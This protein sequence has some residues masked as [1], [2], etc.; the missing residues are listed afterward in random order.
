M[1]WLV[2]KKLLIYYTLFHILGFYLL[3]YLDN[4]SITISGN[5]LLILAP[6][7]SSIILFY[8]YHNL[9]TSDKYIW[10]FLSIGSFCYFIAV[11]ARYYNRLSGLPDLFTM[12]QIIC[13]LIAFIYKIRC[14]GK[15]LNLIKFIFDTCIIMTVA[16]TFSW[17]FIIREILIQ[18]TNHSLLFQLV[19][20]G[21]PLG[22]LILFF[23][24]IV[25]CLGSANFFPSRVLS[26]ILVS[27]ALQVGADSAY[28]YLSLTNIPFSEVLFQPLGSLALLLM[29]I[30]GTFAL[31]TVLNE[32][33]AIPKK[34]KKD[35]LKDSISLR[36]L[37]PYISVI[38]LFMMMIFQNKEVKSLVIGSAISILLVILRHVFTSLE[39]QTLL[40]KYHDLTEKLEQKI[41][42]RTEELS[43]KNQQLLAAVRKMKHMAYH[44]V[45]SGLPNRRM[46]LERLLKAMEQ[47]N[48]NHFK[49]AVIFIDLD[50]F[51]NINDTLGHEFG[52]LLLKHVSHQMTKSVRK[53]DTIS[54]QGG[55]EFTILLNR[56][57]SEEDV[58]PLVERIRSIVAKPIVISGQE[59]HVSM[60]IGIAFYPSD[61]KSTEEIMKNADM[62][63]YRAKEE[64]RDNYKFFSIDM[65]KAISRK[66][67]L[68][69][70]LRKALKNNEF[71][72][73]YQPQVSLQTGEIIGVEALLRWNTVEA[74]MVAPNHFI[75]V[76]EESG[77]IIP[78]GEWVL[79]HA[80]MQGKA[81]HDSGHT[82]LK[83]AV[84][85]SPVQFLHANLVGMVM[86]AL[87]TTGFDPNYLEL[88]IT[89]GVAFTDAET[90]IKK[91]QEIRDLGVQISIDDFGTG[92]SSFVYLKRFPINAL[93][94]PKPFI[95]DVLNNHKDKAL[96]ETMIY[97]AH[98]LDL[99]VIAEGI[100]KKDQLLFLKELNCDAF[101][102][103]LYS[104]PLTVTQVS[105]MIE[106]NRSAKIS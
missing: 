49:V 67:T 32:N 99:S 74:G 63:M 62:A 36:L 101:Q 71:V 45:L 15:N 102:G 105:A 68:E 54:R 65:N 1:N 100:E 98:S 84:N 44:D 82:H 19:S 40:S 76:A 22:D 57:R 61:G 86:K 11:L 69:N 51:K 96:V 75:P 43:S 79:T 59:L 89:E 2:R 56:I 14:N 104:K 47:A 83:V 70:G 16:V 34:N 41:G 13:Y 42:E 66:M 39:N 73:N 53:I 17:H 37:L 64:G 94:I 80:C 31:E 6:L 52:D 21:Y 5:I 27:L 18:Y 38:L 20:I 35:Y 90:A 87:K 72:L 92:Y 81:W 25:F 33:Q 58:I 88:E 28:L 8:V 10:L 50:R 93:K 48:R 60:S 97:L 55:D 3:L 77:L 78:M 103:D 85:L 24:A 4:G 106:S 29:A 46:F 9:K 30:A 7:L 95:Q 23:G 91:M 12:L 26:F